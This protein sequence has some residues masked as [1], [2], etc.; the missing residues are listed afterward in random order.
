[1][2]KPV[3]VLIIAPPGRLRDSL[4][5]LLRSADVTWILEADTFQAGLSALAQ[6]QP[7]LVVLDPGGLVGDVAHMLRQLRQNGHRR[8]L[9]WVRTAEQEP[10]ARQ[11]GAEETLAPGLSTAALRAILD[12]AIESNTVTNTD[13]VGVGSLRQTIVDAVS[14]DTI[15]FD[16]SLSGQTIVLGSQLDIAK[17]LTIDGSSLASHVKISGN[18]AVRVFYIGSGYNVTLTHLDII[19]SNVTGQVGGG[20]YNAGALTVTNSTVSG[21]RADYGGGIFNSGTLTLQDS[22]L[23]GNSV[24]VHGGGIYNQF[25]TVLLTQNTLSGNSAALSGGGIYNE[26]GTLTLNNSTLSG[27]SATSAGGGIYNEGGTLTLQNSLIGGNSAGDNGPDCYGELVSQGYNLIQ[28]T[29]GC[30]IGGD[31]EHNVTGQDP[32]L[33]PLADN[34]GDTFTH[35]LLPGSPAIDAGGATCLPT[36]QRGVARPQGAACDIGAYEAL[37]QPVLGLAKS[38]VPVSTHY[39]G[40]VTYTIVLNNRGAMSDTNLILTDTLPAEW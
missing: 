23:S 16:A 28:N 25:S 34:G 40:V 12:K 26:K 13:D 37:P 36:D 32:L 2:I 31:T 5:V 20:I 3:T 8:C 27:N 33:G 1:M 4:R 14:G 30:S 11:A 39:H 21:N 29:A 6:A 17:N 19:S 18:D 9:V 22:T 38:V 7:T 35:A 10:Q 24:T 15:V